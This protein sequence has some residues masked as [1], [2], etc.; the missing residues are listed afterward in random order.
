MIAQTLGCL[1]EIGEATDSVLSSMNL[2]PFLLRL[3][4][5]AKDAGSTIQGIC[6]KVMKNRSLSHTRSNPIDTHTEQPDISRSEAQVQRI[7]ELLSSESVAGF[8]L[9]V[10]ENPPLEACE[11]SDVHYCPVA[12]GIMEVLDPVERSLRAIWCRRSL[13]LDVSEVIMRALSLRLFAYGFASSQQMVP[14]LLNKD[15][16]SLSKTPVANR[17]ISCTEESMY[18]FPRDA[19]AFLKT[20]LCMSKHWETPLDGGSHIDHPKAPC[21]CGSVRN[22]AGAWQFSGISLSRFVNYWRNHGR[23]AIPE[24]ST[25]VMSHFPLH[26]RPAQGNSI[27][28]S[29]KRRQ[30][31]TFDS[32]K[33]EEGSRDEGPVDGNVAVKEAPSQNASGVSDVMTPSRRELRR[34]HA[35]PTTNNHAEAQQR[36]SDAAKVEGGGGACSRRAADASEMAATA[37][38]R[39]GQ[40]K[41]RDVRS[42][43]APS[44]KGKKKVTR[45][46]GV[47]VK[48][49]GRLRREF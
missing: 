8:V 13:P 46:K 19:T 40:Q 42:M 31:R 16:L 33:T 49:M 26:M 10:V 20:Q 7:R 11:G 18:L 39:A 6:E 15:S 27:G 28:N 29:A 2:R 30:R 23:T 47:S 3:P 24:I 45:T 1:Q 9:V 32:M 4:L 14:N 12:G 17:L 5:P 44:K 38:P 37:K 41:K 34:D 21:R 36:Q 22:V 48:G 35:S 25:I 43:R